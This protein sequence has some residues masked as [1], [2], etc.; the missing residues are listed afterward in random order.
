MIN[1][2][3]NSHHL[4]PLAFVLRLLVALERGSV[5]TYEIIMSFSLVF[6]NNVLLPGVSNPFY[7][8]FV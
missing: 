3:I 8:L 5:G 4:S 7:S 6:R 1:P 2:K